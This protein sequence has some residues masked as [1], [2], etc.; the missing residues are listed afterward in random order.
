MIAGR[1]PILAPA[2][3]ALLAMASSQHSRPRL[4]WNVTASTPIGLYLEQVD[5]A[6]KRGDLVVVRPDPALARWM[7]A[8]GYIGKSVPLVKRVAAAAGARVC[9]AGVNLSIDGLT[10]ATALDRDHLGRPLPTWSGC[11]VLQRDQ[12]FL[13]NPAP[14]SL[15]GRYFGP[16]S[17]SAVVGR[18]VP[19]WL[20]PRR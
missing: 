14:T 5:V 18:A 11:T 16:T 8:R 15:D 9:R 2:T 3:A 10:V 13:L 20:S 19:L 6:P 17:S 7:V 12:L 4:L 1:L